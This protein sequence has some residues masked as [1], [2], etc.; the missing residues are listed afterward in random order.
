M[1]KPYECERCGKKFSRSDNLT[2]H[3]RTHGRDGGKGESEGSGES[4]GGEESDEVYEHHQV[5]VGGMGKDD[6]MGVP[7]GVFD[8]VRL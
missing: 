2:Q 4:E 6:T 3:Q 7:M 8:E 5:H 1:E